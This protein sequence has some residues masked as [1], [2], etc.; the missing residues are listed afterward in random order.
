MS[1]IKTLLEMMEDAKTGNSDDVIF[2]TPIPEKE[3]GG[4]PDVTTETTDVDH[5]DVHTGTVDIVIDT[6]RD[7]T[8]PD[9][10]QAS[11]EQLLR[12]SS[13]ID[14]LVY[15]NRMGYLSNEDF[16]MSVKN[17]IAGIGNIFGHTLNLFK[18]AIFFSWR[19]FKRSELDAYL[20]SNMITWRRIVSFET[21]EVQFITLPKPKGMVGTYL[22]AV[23]SLLTYLDN[24][25][26]LER[27]TRFNALL[28]AI[29]NELNSKNDKFTMRVDDIT[30]KLL[31]DDI[32]KNFNATSKKF[33]TSNTDSELFT[34]LFTDVGELKQVLE[35]TL[36]GDIHLRQVASVYDNL[37][38]ASELIERIINSS[39]SLTKSQANDL[40]KVV[41]AY[42]VTFDH[43]AVAVNDLSR[44]NHNLTL[45][46]Q[47]IANVKFK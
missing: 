4:E 37:N 44:V 12:A 40:S 24:L 21:H 20:D 26:L 39:T 14:H 1:Q 34:K 33:T 42:A 32:E 22:P 17:A 43:Y 29:L 36:S 19:D 16:F 5:K 30:R 15:N 13:Y 9:Q 38:E 8:K 27:S 18:T 11:A 7:A 31:P 41:R 10:L 25:N 28:E 45:D 23:N 3:K 2:N 47:E 35:T 46:L 6:N